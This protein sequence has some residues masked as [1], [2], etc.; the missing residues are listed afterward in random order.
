M[1]E[2]QSIVYE[3]TKIPRRG[4]RYKSNVKDPYMSN[5]YQLGPDEN[6]INQTL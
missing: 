6:N 4:K 1:M 5:V 2:E 3:P